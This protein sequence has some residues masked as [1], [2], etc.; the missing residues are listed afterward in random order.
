M[1]NSALIL[2]AAIFGVASVVCEQLAYQ[3]ELQLA[4]KQGEEEAHRGTVT[5]VRSELSD[6]RSIKT[7][8]LD[9]ILDEQFLDGERADF[10]ELCN[11]IVF[12]LRAYAPSESDTGFI[13]LVEWTS[14]EERNLVDKMWEGFSEGLSENCSYP[15]MMAFLDVNIDLRFR[16]L[17]DISEFSD[18]HL[19]IKEEEVKRQIVIVSSMIFELFALFAVLIIVRRHLLSRLTSEGNNKTA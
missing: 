19:D 17:S 1:K 15:G 3:V 7:G 12:D 18:A 9:G 8:V 2:M 10:A 5:L 16:H 14:D 4:T 13:H 6:L 11:T